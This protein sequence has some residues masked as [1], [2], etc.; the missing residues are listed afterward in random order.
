[1][2]RFNSSSPENLVS[3]PYLLTKNDLYRLPVQV[4]IEIQYVG[5]QQRLTRFRYRGAIA[6]I[7]R[8]GSILIDQSNFAGVNAVQ[9]NAQALRLDIASWKSQVG[10]QLLTPDY[11][12]LDR[13]RPA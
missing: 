2:C 6:Y 11:L 13:I 4:L 9:G 1:M 7:N 3:S 10:T 8:R 12:A 5:L